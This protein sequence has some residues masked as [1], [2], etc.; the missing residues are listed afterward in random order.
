MFIEGIG[1]DFVKTC[2]CKL[3]AIIL[4]ISPLVLL[5][6]TDYKESIVQYTTADRTP[7]ISPDYSGLIIPPNIAPLNFM[8]EEPAQKYHVKIY[9]DN[10]SNID[11]FSLSSKIIIPQKQWGD[12]LS[13][14][15]GSKLFIDIYTKDISGAWMRYSSI[16][17]EISNDAIDGFVVYR[18][19]NFTHKHFNGSMTIYCRDLSSYRQKLVMHNEWLEKGCINCH[20][21]AENKSDKML[22]GVRSYQVYG[23]GT[24]LVEGNKISYLDTKFGYTSWHPSGRLVAYSI[25]ELPMIYHSSRTETRDTI[26]VDSLIAYYRFD[27][28]QVK[29]VP[30]FA[31]KD[32]LETWPQWSADGKYLYSC[33]MPKLWD[34]AL[35]EDAA[36]HY[37]DVKYDLAR[38]SY[39]IDADKWGPMETVVSAKDTG[40]SVA[41]PIT[42]P[43]GR[44][45]TFCMA[46]YGYFP[47]WNPTSDIYMI[48]LQSGN[49]DYKKLSLSS[50]QSEGWRSFSSNSKW[51]AFSSKR[52]D[53][54]F[55]R[56]YFS[57]IDDEGNTSKPFIMPQK[58]PAYYDSCLDTFTVPEF[59]TAPV[60]R[61]ANRLFNAVSGSQKIAV[62]SP[63]T[64]AT[65]K[66][67]TADDLDGNYN[68]REN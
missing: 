3:H 10:G 32:H 49:N 54:V 27:E 43:D 50:D 18:R 17:N 38:A 52:D 41:M 66:V 20:A 36:K 45:L 24:L 1:D 51:I 16:V 30:P 19:M 6:C 65:P 42:S 2:L 31:R 28:K 40:M 12:L 33:N 26:G 11:I 56:T 67:N 60:M 68:E 34:G 22:M 53:G 25:D 61:T 58:D 15:K 29:K 5:S 46:E 62:D 44:W 57:Y 59:I 39:D 13:T 48:D 9:S 8:V 64:G 21:S 55:T 37:K 63:I 4:L 7:D 14:N 35:I 47:P 23:V